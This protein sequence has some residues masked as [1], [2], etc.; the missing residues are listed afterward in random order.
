VQIGIKQ[1]HASVS[2]GGEKVKM[3]Q[4]VVVLLLRGHAKT[5]HRLALRAIA[6]VKVQRLRHPRL[7]HPR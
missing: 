6:D 2:A 3:I 4:A 1:A 5:L 7:R